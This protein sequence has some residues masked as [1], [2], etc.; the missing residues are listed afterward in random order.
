MTIF[1]SKAKSGSLTRIEFFIKN[2]EAEPLH[3]MTE[4]G[5]EEFDLQQGDK[6]RIWIPI[7]DLQDPFDP[8][9]FDTWPNNR[10]I[11]IWVPPFTNCE[12]IKK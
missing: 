6:L 3:I 12:V 7:T 1:R 5:C 8:L 2:E 10:H 11:S 9:Q 4:P